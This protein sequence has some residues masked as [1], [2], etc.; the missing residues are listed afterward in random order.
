MA[1]S[2]NQ[3][4]SSRVGLESTS[5]PKAP[6]PKLSYAQAVQAKKKVSLV[7][8]D[9]KQPNQDATDR[10]QTFQSRIYREAKS[11]GA[12]LLDLSEVRDTCTDFQSL[13]IVM[14]QHPKIFG[15]QF[16]S[17]NQRR[18]LELYVRPQDDV[19]DIKNTVS[20][21]HLPFVHPDEIRPGPKKS[22]APFGEVIDVGIITEP[23]LG[24]F[25]GSGYA[26]LGRN[27]NSPK[28]HDLSYTVNWCKSEDQIFHCTW[29]NM[30]TWC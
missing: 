9:L 20:L 25:M 1:L 8:P 23:K 27:P 24:V 13:Q 15:C 16:L 30:P 4:F 14:E 10:L 26:V 12:L 3:H 21:T 22:L 29:N 28:F 7:H 6:K 18:Y 11:S 2:N 17:D 5:P 19:N